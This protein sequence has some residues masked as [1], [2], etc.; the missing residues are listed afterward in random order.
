MSIDRDRLVAEL[1]EFREIAFPTPPKGH[2]F[3]RALL[4][5]AKNAVVIGRV[6]M[7][8]ALIEELSALVLM[9]YWLAKDR[10]F[11]GRLYFGR[12]KRYKSLS[13]ALGRL[14]ARQKMATLRKVTRVPKSVASN[15]DRMLAIRDVF[16]HVRTIENRN[17]RVDR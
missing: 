13:D 1:A 5:S 17:G 12:I 7:D 9:H 14:P 8:C 10:V 3:E 2:H 16:A 15:I 11:M 4:I 6:L